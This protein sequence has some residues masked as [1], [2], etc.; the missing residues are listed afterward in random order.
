MSLSFPQSKM[1]RIL[2][3]SVMLAISSQV[4]TNSAENALASNIARR[5]LASFQEVRIN[6]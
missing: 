6:T 3:F 5:Q 1:E 4:S 2:S